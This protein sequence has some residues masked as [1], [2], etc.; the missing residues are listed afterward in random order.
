MPAST[1]TEDS[2]NDAFD[3]LVSSM[4]A[5]FHASHSDDLRL[6]T[7]SAKDLFGVYLAALPEA[8]RQTLN[9]HACRRFVDRFGKLV[10][11]LPDGT[12]RSLFWN[13]ESAP[14]E[15]AH[16]V[17]ALEHHVLRARVES[18]FFCERKTWGEAETECVKAPFKWRHLA[19]SPHPYCRA[20]RYPSTAGQAM[21]EKRQD[22]EMLS[23]ALTEFS[24]DVVLQAHSLLATGSLFRAEKCVGAAKWLLELHDARRAAVDKKTCEQLTWRAVALAPPGFCHVRSS[25]IGTL[26][27]DLQAG[28]PFEDIKRRFD[29]KMHPLQ[30]LRPTAEPSAGN[31]AQAERIVAELQSA[32]ALSRRFARLD[33]VQAV[34]RPQEAKLAQPSKPA[35]VFAHLLGR[36]RVRATGLDTPSVTMTWEK[37]A[38]TVLP[39]VEALAFYVPSTVATYGALITASDPG[40][41]PILQWDMPDTRNSVSWYVYNEGSHPQRWGLTAGRFHDVTAVTLQPSMWNDGGARF[42]HHG[43]KVFFLLAGAKDTRY[44]RG[45][46]FFPEFLRSEYHSIRKTMEAHAK[47]SIVNDADTASACGIALQK[48]QTWDHLFRATTRGVDVRYKLSGWD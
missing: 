46:G 44:A 45:A 27:Q 2:T 32:G 48:G 8:S 20:F 15:F 6:F 11:I 10:T 17:R 36:N 47:S 18:V 42:A 4:Q 23:R 43:A 19:V 29:E 1:S 33:E 3:M 28:M 5:T 25:M 34:W 12:L 22:Y 13:S 41:P 37:F 7:T 39:T 40:A 21:S 16:A 38:R 9:C 35:G 26:L 14:P 31:V 30:Y 24:L